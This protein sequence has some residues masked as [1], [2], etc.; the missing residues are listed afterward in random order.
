MK[1]EQMMKKDTLWS[2]SW[3]MALMMAACSPQE[4]DN[5]SLDAPDSVAGVEVS[6]LVA[7]TPKST[8]ELEFVNTSETSFPVTAIWDLGNGAKGKGEKIIGQ[9]PEKGDYTVV[10]TLYAADGSSVSKSRVITLKQDD[11]SLIDTPEY[12]MLTGGADNAAGKTWVLDQYNNFIEE[13]ATALGADIRGHMGLGPANAYNQSWWGA[14]PNEKNSWKLYDFKFTFLQQGARLKLETAGEGYGRKACIGA[15]GF[16]ATSVNGDDALFDYSGGNYT[17]SI[18]MGGAHPVLELSDNAFMG[19]YCGTQSYEI[20]YQTDEVMCLRVLNATESQDWLFVYC[21]ESLNIDKPPV[22]K[23]PRA[24]PLQENFEA[25]QLHLLFAP[26][27]MG[28]LTQSAYSNPAPVPVNQSKKVF[29]YQK[30]DNFYSNLSWV[31]DDYTFDLTTQHKIR[32]KA[33]I[34]S[35]NDYDTENAIAGEWITEKRLRPQ[36]AVK[37]QNAGMGGNAWQTQTEIVKADLPLNQWVELEFD[38]S[39]VKDR[40]DYDKIVIQFGGEGHAGSGIF[41]FDDFSFDE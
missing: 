17:F 9:Y 26:E 41:F 30:S 16:T 11:F 2:L 24:V 10:L 1:E 8:N 19:Y 31:A 20:I 7:A 12:R 21:L 5:Y 27:N 33:Y 22:V 29:L 4:F 6:F 39:S 34:P 25:D 23:T 36:V 3:L 38:F 14:G 15:A 35:Y 13:V 37:L 40:T 28:A 18:K 32:L